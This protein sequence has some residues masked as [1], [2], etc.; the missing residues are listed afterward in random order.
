MYDVI[1]DLL[2]VNYTY[3]TYTVVVVVG[4]LITEK[5]GTVL[6]TPLRSH[7]VLLFC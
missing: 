1:T 5:P 3:N 4:F 7:A 6:A 2:R